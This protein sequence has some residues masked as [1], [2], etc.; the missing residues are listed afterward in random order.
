MALGWMVATLE[1]VVTGRV[2]RFI[3]SM[4]ILERRLI[5][6]AREKLP[7]NLHY[8][9]LTP[10]DNQYT[11]V[12]LRPE[13]FYGFGGAQ[14]KD[15]F[16]QNFTATGWQEILSAD[17]SDGGNLKTRYVMGIAGFVFRDANK[18]ITQIQ[19][20][21]GDYSHPVINIEHLDFN[22]PMAIVFNIKES[23]VDRFIFTPDHQPKVFADIVQTGY[24]TVAPLGLAALPKGAAIKQ[25]Y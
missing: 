9:G 17:L 2:A 18:N 25:T 7:G 8:G 13:M 12:P 6:I 21:N 19:V 20:I 5:Q 15:S 16:R 10:E 4:K 3:E 14:L 23:K 24:Q 1:D 11:L 22:K